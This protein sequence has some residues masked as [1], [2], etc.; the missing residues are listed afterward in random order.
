MRAGLVLLWAAGAIAPVAARADASSIS[1]ETVIVTG[2]AQ[3]LTGVAPSANMGSV[4][5]ADLDLRP[6]LRPGEIVET[7]P[8]VI[9]TQH[10]GSGKANQYFLRGFNLDHGTDLAIDLDGTPVNMPSHAH[11]QGYSDLNFVIPELIQRVDYKKGP[12][13][14]D[15]G[16]FGSA[17]AF[18][19]RYY[20]VLP[21][22]IARVEGGQFGYGRVLLADNAGLG[23]G[24]LIYALEL[25]HNDGPWV[26][27]D[28]ARK[29]S[30]MLRYAQGDHDKGW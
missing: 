26:Q 9:I 14:A 5:A 17:G 21:A 24:N 6:L 22:G 16:D 20:D 18:S 10:S 13:Y 11:G 28:D 8:G 27:G 1:L 7:I 3:D 25:E 23:T 29:A 4:G 12:Y 30:G 19:I 2:R 15:V